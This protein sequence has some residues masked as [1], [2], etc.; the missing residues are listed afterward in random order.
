MENSFNLKKFLAEGKMLKEFTQTDFNKAKT[1]EEIVNLFSQ[2][3]RDLTPFTKY[4][5]EH[6]FLG[7]GKNGKVFRIGNSDKVIKITKN[8]YDIY[9][10]EDLL[11]SSYK[12]L[13]KIYNVVGYEEGVKNP[14][15]KK[16]KYAGVIVMEYLNEL[17]KDLFNLFL[18][19][20][21]HYN[22][23][24]FYLNNFIE[25]EI[26]I[27]EI[28]KI[29][30]ELDPNNENIIKKYN[31]LNQLKG[32]RNDL[33]SAFDLEEMTDQLDPTPG[34]FLMRGNTIVFSDIVQSDN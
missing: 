34:N 9:V 4:Q 26:E 3:K 1:W 30:I 20:F 31:F 19:L 14:Y 10:A 21:P 8:I 2:Y 32:I 7:S 23:K 11:G 17:P 22:K 18:M 12:H 28:G 27:D 15:S 24:E 16:S 5:E 33:N 29:L 25:G 6:S 13:P